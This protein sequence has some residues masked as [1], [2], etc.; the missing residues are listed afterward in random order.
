MSFLLL[1]STNTLL[2]FAFPFSIPQ[3]FFFRF[4]LWVL[5][6][7]FYNLFTLLEKYLLNNIS[8]NTLSF[9]LVKFMPIYPLDMRQL[10]N[11]GNTC[12][13]FQKNSTHFY[14]IKKFN[15]CQVYLMFVFIWFVSIFSINHIVSNTHY[16][17]YNP[18]ICEINKKNL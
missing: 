3:S 6:Y 9:Y 10:Q 18:S 15:P 14:K 16:I 1:R 8:S 12:E 7:F 17:I 5:H 4:E 13:Y 2:D 11:G